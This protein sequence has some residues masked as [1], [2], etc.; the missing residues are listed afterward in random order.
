MVPDTM[1]TKLARKL[2]AI[3]RWRFMAV[4]PMNLEVKIKE[5]KRQ[6]P[7]KIK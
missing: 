2:I 7:R 5:V 1:T 3:L 4:F 6:K